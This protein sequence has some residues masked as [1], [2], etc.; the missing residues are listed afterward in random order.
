MVTN[1][2]N[3]QN[4]SKNQSKNS[5]TFNIRNFIDQLEPAKEKGKYICPVCSGHNLSIDKK[6]GKYQCFNG[7]ECRDIREAI[8]PWDE[9]MA[10]RPLNNLPRKQKC[11]PRSPDTEPALIPSG[12]LAIARLPEVPTDIPQPVKPQFTPRLA[13]KTLLDKGVSEE[14][15]KTITVTTYNY[16]ADKKAHRYEAQTDSGK[17][18]EKTFAIS[19]VDEQG[20]TQWN[21]GKVGWAAYRQD[22]AIAAMQALTEDK[23]PVLL[24]HE[25]EKCVEAGRSQRLAGITSLGNSNEDDLVCI[26]NETKSQM[27][28][29][30][31]ILAHCRDNDETGIQKVEKLA[32]AC[33]RSQIPF[34]AIDLKR[35]KPDLCDKGDIYDILASGMNGEE[36]AQLLLEQIKYVRQDLSGLAFGDSENEEVEVLVVVKNFNQVAFDALYGDKPWICANEKLYCREE[37]Y[38]EYIPEALEIKR[39]RDF[40]NNYSVV[41]K[42]K[43]TFPYAN[44]ASVSQILSWVKMSL[45][46]DARLLNP[47]GLNCTNGVVQLHWDGDKPSW[48]LAPSTAEHYYTYRPIATYDPDADPLHCDRLLEALEPAQREIFL[49]TIAASLDLKTVRRYKGRA[50]RALLLKGDGS[51]GKDSLREVVALMYGRQGMTGCTLTDFAAYDS[52]RKFSLAKLNLSRVNW[53]SENANS[54]RLDKIQ[55]LK[56]FITGD[57]LDSERKGVDG[58]EYEPNGIAIFNINDIPTMQGAMEAILSRYGIVEFLKTFKIGAD[59]SLGELE[60]DPRFKYDPM[61]MQAMVVPA[62][63]NRVLQALSD[64]MIEGI[65]YSC[66]KEALE[67]IQAENCHLFQFCQETGLTYDPSST[68]AASEIWSKLE[69]WY[70]DNDILTYDGSKALWAEQ[71]RPSDKNIKAAHQVVPRFLQI[72]PKAKRVMIPRPGGGKPIAAIAGI[73]FVSPP[74]LPTTP[75]TDEVHIPKVSELKPLNFTFKAGDRIKC[76]PT[77]NHSENFWPVVAK[78]VSV[79]TDNGWFNG[80]TIEY[81]DRKKRSVT[82]RIAGGNATWILQKV[83]S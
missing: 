62:F 6:T 57:P 4:S 48:K 73:A 26:L 70:L 34:V 42:N 77:R 61:F 10:G 80:C 83:L 17:G 82:V 21:K 41:N 81:H 23:I 12:E 51:N 72:F 27:G 44:S 43:I 58:E 46:V 11:A 28:D 16:R 9:V 67:G 3:N 36:L 8:A 74:P 7:C 35:I 15:L 64:L 59:P 14:G 76:Y 22:E 19:R 37:N 32:K 54:T 31:F 78:V 25:G 45:K 33:V 24:S 79:E 65:D 39:I 49:R 50:V 52:G 1:F 75:P 66:T 29:R 13:R 55:S 2:V 47:P 53:S 56:A 18:Y 5:T 63:L 69:S 40:C 30:V 20:K 38:Y 68:V 71:V 60:A